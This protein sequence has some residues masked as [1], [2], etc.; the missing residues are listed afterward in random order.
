MGR[1]GRATE[2][3]GR[4]SDR[5]S[6]TRSP[7]ATQCLKPRAADRPSR[8]VIDRYDIRCSALITAAGDATASSATTVNQYRWHQTN[9]SDAPQV[10]LV[11]RRR[12]YARLIAY[13]QLRIKRPL[14]LGWLINRCA[15]RIRRRT[16]IHNHLRDAFRHFI[17][18]GF[19]GAAHDQ[20]GA[21]AIGPIKRV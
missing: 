18:R 13:L 11:F 9:P 15:A 7:L 3:S 21:V 20:I 8:L 6:P 10:H 1:S 16:L 5:K 12:A 4:R 2:R 17:K 14:F 19:I